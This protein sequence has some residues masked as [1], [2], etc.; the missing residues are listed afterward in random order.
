[1]TEK[2]VFY[3]IKNIVMKLQRCYYIL[4]TILLSFSCVKSI[5][6]VSG[7]RKKSVLEKVIETG[8]LK[9]VTDFSSTSYFIYRGQPMGYQYELL[10]ELANHLGVRLEVSVN[11]DLEKQ[12]EMLQNG[13]VDLIAANLTITKNR[14]E[15][16]AF[17]VPHIRTRQVL[18]QRKPEN[19]QKLSNTALEDSLIRNQL[20]LANK[21]VHVQK[22]SSYVK[23]LRSLSDEIGDSI[24]IIELDKGDEQLIEMVAKGEIEYTVCDEIVAQV[25]ELYYDNID[26]KTPVSFYQNLAWAVNKD[27]LDLKESIDTWL[28][29]FKQTRKYALIIHK[30]FQNKKS[31]EIVSSDYYASVTGKISPYDALIKEYSDEIQWDWRLV[32][33]MIYQ[34]SRFNPHAK[35]RAGA[36]GLMQLMP[37][38]GQRFGAYPGSSLQTQIRAG[39]MYIKWLDKKLSDVK[40][41]EERKKFILAAYNIGLGHIMDA[42]ALAAKNKKNP[43]VWDHNVA[44][45]LLLKS[46]PKYYS[47]PIVKYGY[48]HGIETYQYV[49][50]I[51]ERY[52]H[53][54]NLVS[55]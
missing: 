23:R 26:C 37:I 43:N 41:P 40:N 30:Y 3:M 25:S 52:G 42:R 36:Y 13:E 54:K 4:F 50:D 1:M 29:D 14:R 16:M 12:F 32:A 55:E 17:T 27:A 44:D 2:R 48:C 53:Y 34:E 18:V 19:W 11:N 5:N 7:E 6:P 35:S 22:N 21:T 49:A 31:S 39:L 8:V 38:T 15:R 33:S 24:N 51:M 46:D 28:T 20:D 47:D 45:F 9:V 10:Q